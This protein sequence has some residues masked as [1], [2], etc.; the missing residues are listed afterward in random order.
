M[1]TPATSTGVGVRKPPGKE[2]AGKWAPGSAGS[3]GISLALT[4]PHR[5]CAID[6]MQQGSGNRIARPGWSLASKSGFI[7]QVFR[8]SRGPVAEHRRRIGT[9]TVV[10]GQGPA[11]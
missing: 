11:D 9:S 1:T 5:L 2:G 8:A 4:E 6:G 10:A 3:M 7:I